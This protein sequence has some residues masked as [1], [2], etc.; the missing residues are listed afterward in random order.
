MGVDMQ[1]T[2]ET[3]GKYGCYF[4]S[5]VKAGEL[6]TGIKRDASRLFQ[7][8][9]EKG[10]SEDDCFLVRPDLIL[11]DI[12]GDPWKVRKEGADYIPKQGEIVILRYEYKTTAGLLAHFVL[13]GSDGKT[14]AYD[15]YYP[16]QTVA[17]GY[18]V[19]KRVLEKYE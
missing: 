8:A 6:L 14:I 5:L 19:S 1:R 12:T 18:L 15:P 17:K 11:Q 3:I 13:A 10:W 2:A 9:V 4:L 16:S 7:K